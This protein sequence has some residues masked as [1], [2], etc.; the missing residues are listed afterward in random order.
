[1]QEPNHKSSNGIAPRR[2]QAALPALGI[3]L[4]LV[5]PIYAQNSSQSQQQSPAQQMSD[6]AQQEFSHESHSID[7]GTNVVDPRVEASRL[8][9]ANAL[10]QMSL[11]ADT[12]KLLR[13]VH[14]LDAEIGKSS[15][16]SLNAD[17]LRKLAEI[18]KLAHSVKEKMSTPVRRAE[19][20]QEE[21]QHH[22]STT[23]HSH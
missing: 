11:V 12:N 15:P 21:P 18:E 22:F 10:R 13:L 17:Q 5:T 3:A 14:E 1:M 7:G 20:Y 4:L 2:L 8:R 16:D 6:E 23:S 9:T 19:E